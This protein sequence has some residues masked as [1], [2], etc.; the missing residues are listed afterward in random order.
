MYQTFKVVNTLS[1]LYRIHYWFEVAGDDCTYTL[2]AFYYQRMF[3]IK[4]TRLGSR[5]KT[6]LDIHVFNLFIEVKSTRFRGIVTA[7]IIWGSSVLNPKPRQSF[8]WILDIGGTTENHIVSS[9]N[10]LCTFTAVSQPN[11]TKVLCWISADWVAIW[12][13]QVTLLSADLQ[14]VCPLWCSQTNTQQLEL[15]PT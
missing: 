15:W 10:Q 13:P 8:S 12:W 5:S 3:I 1:A 11:V 2:S 14:A 7:L 6:L 4:G 9:P